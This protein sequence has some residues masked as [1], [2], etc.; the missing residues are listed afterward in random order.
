MLGEVSTLQ[1][2][3]S[4][5]DEVVSREKVIVH[6]SDGESALHRQC[7]CQLKHA[8]KEGIKAVRDVVLL[9]TDLLVADLDPQ[10]GIRLEEKERDTGNK[11]GK[12]CVSTVYLS[13]GVLRLQADSLWES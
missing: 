6:D 4:L 10:V 13:T 2:N 5:P 7:G 11:A 1:V 12:E 3:L 8:T 9:V